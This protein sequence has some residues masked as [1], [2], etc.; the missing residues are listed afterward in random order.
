MKKTVN[1]PVTGKQI[2]GDSCYCVVL[3]VDGEAPEQALPPGVTLTDDARK[4][5]L[6]CQYYED[7]Q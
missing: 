7:E 2:D 3:V 4:A 1:C 6:A 5:C